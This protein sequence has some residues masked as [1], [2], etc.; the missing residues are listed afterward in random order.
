MQV[1]RLVHNV[2]VE[3]ETISELVRAT[4]ALQIVL[5]CRQNSVEGPGI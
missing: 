4:S 3:M 1:L 2:F 5:D